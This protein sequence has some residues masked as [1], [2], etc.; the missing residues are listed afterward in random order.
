MTAPDFA[1]VAFVVDKPAAGAAIFGKRSGPLRQA[2]ACGGSNIRMLSV[3]R[4]APDPLRP[5]DACRRPDAG[6]DV[7]HVAGAA[8]GLD[9]KIRG[10]ES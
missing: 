5:A 3:G 2:P 4:R 1:Y 7:C 6:I 10:G 9:R 8:A